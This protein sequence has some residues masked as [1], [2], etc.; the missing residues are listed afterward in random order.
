[1]PGP[2][3]PEPAVSFRKTGAAHLSPPLLRAVAAARWLHV[4]STR[5]QIGRARR[6][7]SPPS[8]MDQRRSP[9][10]RPVVRTRLPPS[11]SKSPI[12]CFATSVP[13]ASFN[14]PSWSTSSGGIPVVLH[15][16]L[17]CFAAGSSDASDPEI[18]DLDRVLNEL[19]EI[20]LRKCCMLEVRCFLGLTAQE[21]ADVFGTSKATVDRDLRFVRSWL[22]E[23]FQWDRLQSDRL[24]SPRP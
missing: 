11:S 21:T 18:L 1:M 16:D 23:R 4:Y 3:L 22:Y 5:R 15:E 9:H 20:D 12:L 17:V 8:P 10:P 14:P 24:R 19:E 6:H 2:P 7:H 13:E